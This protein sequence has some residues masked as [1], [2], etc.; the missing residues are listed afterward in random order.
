MFLY[1]AVAF[2]GSAA[3]ADTS[4]RERAISISVTTST[5]IARVSHAAGGLETTEKHASADNVPAAT[6]GQTFDRRGAIAE[7][8]SGG[9]TI[10]RC[11]PSD[12]GA[13]ETR[14]RGVTYEQPPV[15]VSGVTRSDSCSAVHDHSPLSPR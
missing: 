7:S 13:A 9:P 2:E 3:N 14:R 10:A 12:H 1:H 4:S 6:Q 5:A 15:V 11:A 8:I